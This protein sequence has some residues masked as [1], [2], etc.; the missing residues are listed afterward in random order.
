MAE[1]SLARRRRG[2]DGECMKPIAHL[3]ARATAFARTEHGVV[4]LAL[5]AIGLHVVD[6]N[7]L[8]PAPGP[9]RSTI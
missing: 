3:L 8:Q 7:Y 5:G 6:D 9:P 1:G 4:V 2:C